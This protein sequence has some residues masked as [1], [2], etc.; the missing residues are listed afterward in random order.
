MVEPVEDKDFLAERLEQDRQKNGGSGER[1][2][3]KLQ[4]FAPAESVHAQISLVLGD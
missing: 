3:R 1:A 2:K 4:S